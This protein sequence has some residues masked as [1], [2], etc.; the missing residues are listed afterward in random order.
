MKQVRNFIAA[1]LAAIAL[2]LYL[3]FSIGSTLGA[4]DYAFVFVDS[5]KNVYMA[6]PCVSQDRWTLLP[7]LT[8]GQAHKLRMDPEST[9]RN[10]GGF[11]QDGRSLSGQFLEKVGVLSPQQSRWNSDGSWNW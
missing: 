3:G 5:T 7:R 4:P 10:D 8:I 6:P 2:L 11:V 9:C 1:T